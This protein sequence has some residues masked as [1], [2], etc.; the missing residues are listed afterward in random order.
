[1]PIR[2]QFA[3]STVVVV[4]LAGTVATAR[5]ASVDSSA[6]RMHVNALCR[7]F[8]PR[9]KQA[10]ADM[11]SAQAARDLHKTAFGLGELLGET[12][13]QDAAIERTPVPVDAAQQMAR[14][15]QLLR[16]ADVLMR[17]AL[18]AAAAGNASGFAAVGKTLT[19][20]GH[21]LNAAFDDVGLRDCGS[22]QT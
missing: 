19:S 15:L 2:S 4:V 17:R 21:S 20:Y 12:L 7:S 16:T 9:M 1:M 6:Y 14:P 3:A 13:V 5:G 8:T 18:E 22:N 11:K 10:E